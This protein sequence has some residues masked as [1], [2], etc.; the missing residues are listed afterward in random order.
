MTAASDPVLAA[1]ID[2]AQSVKQLSDRWL[3][4]RL[5][6]GAGGVTPARLNVMMLLHEEGP[7][8]MGDLARRSRM[9]PR[10]MTTIIDC[11]EREG[12]AQR[13]PHPTDRRATMI[14]LT[15]AGRE[16]VEGNAGPYQ[17][18]TSLLFDALLP[19]EPEML[20]SVYDRWFSIISEDLRRMGE[21][22]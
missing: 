1:L 6:E 15:K 21:A 8:K 22:A 19:G 5:G 13:R 10:S 4:R 2:R 17:T 3:Q 9:V 18:A 12:L 20:L 14:E 16:A 11:L 7:Q